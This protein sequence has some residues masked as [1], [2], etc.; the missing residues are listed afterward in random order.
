MLISNC[1]RT[2]HLGAACLAVLLAIAA[3]GCGQEEATV[4]PLAGP[5]ELALS[6]DIQAVPSILN[7]DG[8][9]TSTVT[10]QVRDFNGQPVENQTL[11]FTYD[12]DGLLFA[13]GRIEGPLQ[14]G[15]ALTTGIDGSVQ[16]VYQAGTEAGR[17]VVVWCQPYS[18]NATLLGN[19]TR[20]VVIQ[21]R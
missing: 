10:A 5:S 6:V 19:V 8:A 18:T 16:L 9:S 4:P 1:R 15:V 3:T 11:F 17:R 20:F 21:Q 7:A 13:T 2:L 12:G 14:T